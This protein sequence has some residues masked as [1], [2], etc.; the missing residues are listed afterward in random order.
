MARPFSSLCFA[1]HRWKQLQP[2][3]S[4]PF[5]PRRTISISSSFESYI[6]R[7]TA[8]AQSLLLKEVWTF[9]SSG[10]RTSRVPEWHNK[11]KLREISLGWIN[12][13]LPLHRWLVQ[14]QR[15]I[16]YGFESSWS[17]SHK[18]ENASHEEG[19]KRGSAFISMHL[20]DTEDS[21]AGR[22]DTQYKFNAASFFILDLKERKAEQKKGRR[23]VKCNNVSYCRQGP[24]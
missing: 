9:S 24:K 8:P 5:F 7:S 14:M 20:D 10:E 11:L 22:W 21:I 19:A 13:H 15:Q 3:F 23:R 12:L 1:I 16:H 4:R 2:F 18:G 17:Q 6:I